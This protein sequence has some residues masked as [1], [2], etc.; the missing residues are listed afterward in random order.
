L[1]YIAAKAE[2]S[3][4]MKDHAKADGIVDIEISAAAI[5]VLN[6]V[7]IILRCLL[8]AKNRGSRSLLLC[9]WR[10]FVMIALAIVLGVERAS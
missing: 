7:K 2:G 1:G 4:R 10:F 3:S 9:R 6:T 8:R 5:S